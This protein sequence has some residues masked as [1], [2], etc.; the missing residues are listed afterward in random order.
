MDIDNLVREENIVLDSCRS[1]LYDIAE[2]VLSVDRHRWESHPEKHDQR[3]SIKEAVSCEKFGL[4]DAGRARYVFKLPELWICESEYGFIVKFAGK[5]VEGWEHSN[6]LQQNDTEVK[7]SNDLFKSRECDSKL[8][9]FFCPVVDFDKKSSHPKWVVMPQGTR[10]KD[11][12]D[13]KIYKDMASNLEAL[14]YYSDNVGSA[15]KEFNH[16][17]CH[18][19]DMGLG[20]GKIDE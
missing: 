5:A 20:I 12:P 8:R 14:G 18:F 9:K 17:V 11:R 7:T 6:G 10:P 19:V 13:T 3:D 1:A 4:L 2:R 16:N 15:T